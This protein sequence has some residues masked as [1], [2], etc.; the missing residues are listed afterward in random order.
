MNNNHLP[1]RRQIAMEFFPEL[2]PAN[3]VKRLNNWIKTDR[4]LSC[5]LNLYGYKS[6]SRRLTHRQVRILRQYL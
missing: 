5:L 2:A 4:E 1:L 6:R 3:A